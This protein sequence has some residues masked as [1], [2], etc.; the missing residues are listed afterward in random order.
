[1]NI[2][3]GETGPLPE[4]TRFKG[5][6][7]EVNGRLKLVFEQVHI[8]GETYRSAFGHQGYDENGNMY[9]VSVMMDVDTHLEEGEKRLVTLG[10][11]FEEFPYEEVR[12]ELQYSER[13]RP[14]KEII[15]ELK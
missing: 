13:C 12:L 6:E 8:G 4:D 2:R 3:T 1:M 15:V 9:D 7:R 11:L 14:E 10:Y 5:I